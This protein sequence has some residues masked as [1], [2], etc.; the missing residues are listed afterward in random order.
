MIAARQQ[1][2]SWRLDAS[3]EKL[4]FSEVTMR[5]L[6]V[7]D[8]RFV[9]GNRVRG[10]GRWTGRA[11]PAAWRPNFRSCAAGLEHAGNEWAGDAEGIACRGLQR[12]QGDDG[13][14]R[15]RE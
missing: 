13:D 1:C 11:R 3:S 10:G 14:H 6:I 12:H 9:K 5:A 2:S 4:C 7:D 8:S 15:G